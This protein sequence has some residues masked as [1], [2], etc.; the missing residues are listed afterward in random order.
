MRACHR[1]PTRRL[2]SPKA[3]C[4]GP[5]RFGDRSAKS[6]SQREPESLP[7]S[8]DPNAP[9][10]ERRHQ[11]A[12][13]VGIERLASH[14]FGGLRRILGGVRGRVDV[15]R[16]PHAMALQ[17]V[18]EVELHQID[19]RWIDP[20]GR[21][22]VRR[23]RSLARHAPDQPSR[24]VLLTAEPR[25][26][27]GLPLGVEPPRRDRSDRHPIEAPRVHA[28][29]DRRERRIRR[30]DEIA[31]AARLAKAAKHLR[32]PGPARQRTQRGRDIGDG[33][34]AG[35]DP[36]EGLVDP[37]RVRAGPAA[38][39]DVLGQRQ[40]DRGAERPPQVGRGTLELGQ[41]RAEVELGLVHRAAGSPGSALGLGVAASVITAGDGNT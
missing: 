13:R 22:Q 34:D 3:A 23:D 28:L 19:L 40:L 15:P 18:G 37:E 6:Q 9:T 33:R 36:A 35:A 5:Y 11:R 2:T 39:R 41:D 20:R 24:L 29:V 27:V 38:Q 7:S 21:D 26:L 14:R 25:L 30:L 10:G 17:I 8:S 31:R 16:R 1:D 32:P 4:S 12:T